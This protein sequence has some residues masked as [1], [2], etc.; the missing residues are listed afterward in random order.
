MIAYAIDVF[1]VS[2]SLAVVS[3][4][5]VVSGPVVLLGC[6]GLDLSLG[7]NISTIRKLTP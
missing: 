7:I 4:I 1:C 6:F 5:M 3:V 2:K